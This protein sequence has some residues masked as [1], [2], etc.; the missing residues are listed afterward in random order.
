MFKKL[1]ATKFNSIT[2]AAVVIAAAGL[3]SRVLGIVRDRILAGQFGAGN[4][5]DIY[6]AAFRVP[7]LVY[8]LIVLGALSAGFIPVFIG[9]IKNEESPLYKAN[10]Q[11]W[12]LVNN[13]LNIIAL[14]L[15]GAC[16]ILAVLSPW[17]VPLIT[18][19][20][21]GDKLQLTINLTRL[22]FFSPILLGLSGVFGGVLQSYK[23]FFVF[24]LAPVMYN[25]GIIFGA[26]FLTERYNIY[27]LAFGVILGAGLHLLIQIPTVFRL[28][29]GYRLLLNFKDSNFVKIVKMMGP[30]ILGLASTQLNLIVITI[31][32]STLAAGSLT[33][34]NLANNLQSF[35]IGLFGVSFA[36]AAFPVLSKAFANKDEVQFRKT[37]HRTFKQILFFVIPFSILLI[38]LRAQIVRVILGAG[39]FDWNATE[40]TANSLGLFAMSLFAQAL[41]PLL[42]RTFYARHNTK[43]PFYAAFVSLVVNIFLTWFLV[44][45]I[46]VLGLAL[47]FSIS[48][49][50]NFILLV[51]WLKI[52]V[53]DIGH[54]GIL[55]ALA[56][57]S[58]ASLLMGVAAQY[59]KTW[60]GLSV[61]MQRFWGVLTQ[62]FVAGIV[63]IAVFVLVGYLLKT[64]ELLSFM[65][66]LKRKMFKKVKIEKEGIRDSL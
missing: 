52:K 66:S 2:S 7:D 16:L 34:F 6:Y 3:L 26:L 58:F 57:I 56:K 45:K 29:F 54:N 36:L 28:G 31:F 47:G 48:S 27:G 17:L 1:L 51:V 12:N 18:P 40:L 22:M 65:A 50:I 21:S 25:L 46:G 30:R 32:A 38:I 15:F 14:F 4:E 42:A 59:I 55:I 9:L 62:G 60:I 20:F 39:Q 43:L 13:I 10:E 19:G 41:L 33:V 49:I 63:G 11:A 8:N 5:L 61:D 35:A 24:A 37:F 23:R 53:K 64:E 44:Q